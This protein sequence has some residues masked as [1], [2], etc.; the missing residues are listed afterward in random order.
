MV[1]VGLVILSL[2]PRPFATPFTKVVL[3]SPRVPESKTMSPLESTAANASP[4]AI[5][6][7]AVAQKRCQLTAS[8]RGS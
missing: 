8:P 3:P 6:S 4:A 2:T 1:K 5:V 7:S